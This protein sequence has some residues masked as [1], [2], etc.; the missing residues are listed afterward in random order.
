LTPGKKYALIKTKFV[1]KFFSL[2]R[3]NPDRLREF[4]NFFSLVDSKLPICLITDADY[5]MVLPASRTARKK[6]SAG[7]Y[8]S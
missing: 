8:Y 1:P 4:D 5:E 2:S 6:G 3:E 7:T